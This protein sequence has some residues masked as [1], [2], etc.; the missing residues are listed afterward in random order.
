MRRERARPLLGTIVA[1][2]ADFA[3]DVEADA[4][5]DAAFAEVAA[6][7]ALM[8]FHD[9][10]SEV[11]RLN[12]EA[13]LRPVPVDPR[14]F[15]VLAWAQAL[16]Q[17]SDGVFDV[18]VAAAAVREAALP[19]PDDAC[20]PDP[21]AG[22]RDIELIAEASAVRFRRPLWIDLGGVAKGYA[23]DRALAV[24]K[25]R[26]ARQAAVNAGGDLAVFG[27]APEP[28]RLRAPQAPE[29]AAIELTDGALAS[30]GGEPDRARASGLH[31]DMRRRRPA[32]PGRF[33]S[34]AAR[35]CM[36]ADALTKV[37]MAQGEGAGPLLERFAAAAYLSDPGQPWRTLGAAA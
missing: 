18:T 5:I 27:P 35:T 2:R 3:D 19:R 16:S 29:A 9:P 36:A 11:S 25:A 10:A 21:D 8:S 1:V 32:R 34:V 23:V 14:T 12:R 30:S 26:G 31:L 24:L 37:V 17:A 33:V 4:A 28:V 13:H 7:Q 6:V 20:A 15:E 22:W